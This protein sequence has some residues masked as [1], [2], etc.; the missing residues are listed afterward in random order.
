MSKRTT[1]TFEP[2]GDVKSLMKKAINAV[3][4][5]DGHKRGK[6]TKLIN[7]ALRIHFSRHR[8][9]REGDL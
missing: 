2:D 9:K 1:W 6:R 4:G 3:C 8:G 7:E 5:R